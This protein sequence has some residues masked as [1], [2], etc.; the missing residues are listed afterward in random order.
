MLDLS[1]LKDVPVQVPGRAVKFV[2][3]FR[4]FV[5]KQNILA[6]ALAVV[7]GTATNNVVQAMV[8]GLFMPVVNLVIKDQAWVTWGPVIGEIKMAVLDPTGNPIYEDD[9][10]TVVPLDD[11]GRPSKKAHI[12]TRDVPNKLLIG[13]LVWQFTNLMVVGMIVYMMTRYLVRPAPTPP[14]PPTRVCPFCLE[15]VVV[16]AKVCRCCARDLP[17]VAGA[18]NGAAGGKKEGVA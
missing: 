1:G 12:R 15:N 3:D 9:N 6:L 10:G 7:I 18:E 8:R 14:A 13:D 4:G 17:A 5:F 11:H 16:E 2:Q